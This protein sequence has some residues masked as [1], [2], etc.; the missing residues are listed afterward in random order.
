MLEK[1]MELKKE[2]KWMFYLLI[3]PIGI[4]SIYELYSKFLVKSSKDIVEDA[5]KKDDALEKE[6]IRAEESAKIH[7]E[8]AKKIQEKIDNADIDKDWYKK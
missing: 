5:Q 3:I 4:L 8:E 7:Q 1:L 6:Q 2:K